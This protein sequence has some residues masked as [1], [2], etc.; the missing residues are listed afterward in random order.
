MESSKILSVKIVKLSDHPYKETAINQ[1]VKGTISERDGKSEIPRD[2][3]DQA[4]NIRK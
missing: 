3:R 4:N 2:K 1:E